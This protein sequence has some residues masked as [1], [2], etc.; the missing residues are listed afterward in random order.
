MQRILEVLLHNK[1]VTEIKNC[2]TSG[3]CKQC[4]QQSLCAAGSYYTHPETSTSKN[5]GLSH[6]N[7]ESSSAKKPSVIYSV[8]NSQHWPYML[9]RYSN[10]RR[11]HTDLLLK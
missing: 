11:S 8:P 5:S 4:L 7:L 1:E 3:Y 6:A 2:N 9:L 10:I